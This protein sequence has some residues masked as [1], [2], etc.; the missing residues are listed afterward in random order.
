[1]MI[2][3]P[4][5]RRRSRSSYTSGLSLALSSGAA[6]FGLGCSALS[7]N[8]DATA[9]CGASGGAGGMKDSGTSP[10]ATGGAATGGGNATGG[11][12][13]STGSGGSPVGVDASTPDAGGTGGADASG[14]GGT[15]AGPPDATVDAAPPIEAGPLKCAPGTADCDGYRNDRCEVTTDTDPTHCGV[16]DVSCA[17]TGTLTVSCVK[18]VCRPTCDA[19]HVDCNGDGTDGCEVNTKID[20]LNCGACGHAC[21]SDGTSSVACIAGLC[22]PTCETGFGD[23]TTPATTDVDDGCE[24]DLTS[25]KTCGACGHDCLGGA[26]SVN[27]CQPL[28]LASGAT[29]VITVDTKYVHFVAADGESIVRVGLGGGAT[30][31]VASNTRDVDTIV[32]DGTYVYWASENFQNY[33]DPPDGQIYRI[34]SGQQNNAIS[35]TSGLD[36]I[37]LAVDGKNVYWTAG[38]KDDTE[39]YQMQRDGTSPHALSGILP[40]PFDVVTDGTTIFVADDADIVSL[41]VG[42]GAI[43]RTTS[44]STPVDSLSIAIDATHVYFWAPTTT[45]A[46]ALEALPRSMSGS[47]TLVAKTTNTSSAAIASDATYVYYRQTD[48]IHRVKK[49]EFGKSSLFLASPN[50]DGAPIASIVIANGA[51][52]FTDTDGHV[53]KLALFAN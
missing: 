46:L 36:A 4:T 18:G 12:A 28:P 17:A 33:G 35:L 6:L 7:P 23:C 45:T 15:E 29:G 2:R 43:T 34:T 26:C 24:T 42:G 53:N 14:S 44:S 27:Q 50:A 32:N 51:M 5:L 40:E 25:A 37:R 20:P 30:Q 22:K 47:P 13:G 38:D 41:P 19:A 3:L 10:S 31:T 1:M 8:C 52:Y 48:G 9:S 49:T 11:S 16:C 21:S 39:I